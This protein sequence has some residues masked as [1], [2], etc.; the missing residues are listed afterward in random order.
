MEEKNAA[1]EKVK[2]KE[3]P[4][5]RRPTRTSRKSGAHDKPEGNVHFGEKKDRQA[6]EKLI[7]SECGRRDRGRCELE[8]ERAM[9]TH[10]AVRAR[11]VPSVHASVRLQLGPPGDAS[12]DEVRG[13]RRS[14]AL[15][16]RDAAWEVRHDRAENGFV[17]ERVGRGARVHVCV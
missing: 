12:R 2:A 10:R 11:P 16:H 7:V 17:G 5:K 13:G 14:G 1:S 15:G 9:S 4:N 6:E 3:R 8:R